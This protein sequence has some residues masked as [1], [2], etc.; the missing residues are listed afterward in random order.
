VVSEADAELT[1]EQY[2]TKQCEEL[3]KGVLSSAEST[4]DRLK[5]VFRAERAS[6]LAAYDAAAMNRREA[7]SKKATAAA[8][9]TAKPSG[10]ADLKIEVLSGP[11][12]GTERVL[13]PRTRRLVP[14]I[15]RSTGSQFVKNGLSLCDDDEVSTTHAKLELQHG[16]IFLTDLD[17]TN[18]TFLDGERLEASRAYRLPAQSVVRVGRSEMRFE[19]VEA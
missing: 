11:H 14:K 7:V 19:V 15:G 6:V 12:A 13:K 10:K 5:A 8:A 2:L 18:G 3:V 16:W 9:E 4:N 1:V 17:S